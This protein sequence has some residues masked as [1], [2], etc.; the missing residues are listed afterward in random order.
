MVF[1]WSVA[2][3]VRYA[4][5]ALALH[6]IKIYPLEWLR[7]DRIHHTYPFTPLMLLTLRLQTGTHCS[8]SYIRLEPAA[9]PT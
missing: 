3:I 1:A 8:T 9:K 5:Y 7:Y 2:E 6:N 4:T